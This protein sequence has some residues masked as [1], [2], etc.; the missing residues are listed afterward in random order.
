MS[1]T[2]SPANP[3]PETTVVTIAPNGGNPAAVTMPKISPDDAFKS[4]C[5]I[6]GATA[7]FATWVAICAAN[8]SV[9]PSIV[10]NTLNITKMPSSNKMAAEV[11]IGTFMGAF[12][13]GTGSNWSSFLGALI[14]DITKLKSKFNEMTFQQKAEAITRVVT[15]VIAG[16]LWITFCAINNGVSTKLYGGDTNVDASTAAKTA[17]AVFLGALMLTQV[18]GLGSNIGSNLVALPLET[19][20]LFNFM[21]EKFCGSTETNNPTHASEPFTT[22]QP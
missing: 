13:L 16:A 6:I 19:K 11:T 18:V 17:E 20:K 12:A 22:G 9:T 14:I 15:G 5:R 7:T 3:N 10:G 4:A 2:T 21:G 1:R 8:Q